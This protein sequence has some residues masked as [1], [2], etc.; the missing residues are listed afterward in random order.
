MSNNINVRIR[1]GKHGA[2][3]YIGHLDIMRYFQK[4]FRRAELPMAYSQ[5]YHPHQILSFASPLGVGVTSDG[6]YMDIGL[7]EP[8]STE[9]ALRRLN[10]AMVEGMKIY[11]FKQLPEKSK[12]AMAALTHAS[13]RVTYMNGQAPDTE[14]HIR[15]ALDRFY[16]DAESIVIT[17]KTKKSERAVDLK[18][19]ILQFEMITDPAS[20]ENADPSDDECGSIGF[21]MM[22]SSGS[23][24][25]INPKLV[26]EHF[27]RFIGA[28]PA[29][30]PVRI[31]RYDMFTETEN[32]IVSLD[33]VGEDIP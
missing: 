8:I 15:E 12:N 3:K 14:D 23:A 19:L 20:C 28:D 10:E 24:E 11:S 13:Y 30:F 6:E 27:H 5:G 7:T 26:M 21:N 4:A 9:E 18:P 31:Y 17:K 32:G 1:F 2:M 22:V 25:N 33:S 29:A 16:T